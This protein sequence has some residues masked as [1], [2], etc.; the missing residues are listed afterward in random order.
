LTHRTQAIEH[1]RHDKEEDK[2]LPKLSPA[3]TAP[4]ATFPPQ[5][6]EHHRHDEED[7]YLPKLAQASSREELRELTTHWAAA[8]QRARLSELSGSRMS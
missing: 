1:H 2:Y 7:K 3:L 5:A 4:H 8:K 6:F